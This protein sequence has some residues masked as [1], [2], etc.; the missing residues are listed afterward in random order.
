MKLLKIAGALAGVL[1]LL[2][3]ALHFAGFRLFRD[4]A[5]GLPLLVRKVSYRNGRPAGG[6]DAAAKGPLQ[7]I[8]ILT[9]DPIILRNMDKDIL[10]E[11]VKKLVDTA[12][13]I[14][15]TSGKDFKLMLTVTYH[16]DKET[17]NMLQVQEDADMPVIQRLGDEIDALNK[18]LRTKKEDVSVRFYFD[19]A[20][21]KGAAKPAG[22]TVVIAPQEA[23]GPGAPVAGSQE[24]RQALAV[25]AELARPPGKEPRRW[26]SIVCNPSVWKRL[27]ALDAAVAELGTPSTAM[28]AFGKLE[29]RAFLKQKNELAPL[30]AS[31]GF[32][33][34]M[35]SFAEGAARAATQE[36]RKEIYAMI[37]FEIKGKPVTVI[38]KDGALLFISFAQEL[39]WLDV[40]SD[41][42]QPA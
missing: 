36:E 22:K 11:N 18:D 30:Y 29:A 3:A 37:P 13:E 1:V 6:P 9:P 40:I 33:R 12:N 5:G 24:E 39:L 19:T 15:E 20:Y 21:R 16:A 27:K 10:L 2:A 28:T 26:S 34:F 4:P 7:K 31:P 25:V 32:Q 38:D 23:Q 8:E 17:D 42:R 14:L 41:Y 35:A